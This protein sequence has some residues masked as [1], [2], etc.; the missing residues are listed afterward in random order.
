VPHKHS[1]SFPQYNITAPEEEHSPILLL[2]PALHP[3]S[4]QTEE[5]PYTSFPTASLRAQ[6]AVAA[7]HLACTSPRQGKGRPP[8][9]RQ[10]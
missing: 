2:S 1:P 4:A 5:L 3:L 8:A 7:P 10:E 6:E 9:C